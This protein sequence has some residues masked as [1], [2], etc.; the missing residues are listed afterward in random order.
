MHR[1]VTA[2]SS[3]HRG[4]PGGIAADLAS[5]SLATGLAPNPLDIGI[6]FDAVLKH[7]GPV[8][9]KAGAGRVAV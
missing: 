2:K 9:G 1:I 4:I 6:V 7:L 8:G 5:M 3:R